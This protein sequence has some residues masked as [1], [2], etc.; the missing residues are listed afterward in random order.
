[1][2]RPRRIRGLRIAVSAVCGI[3]CLLLVVLWVRSYWR[4]DW[5][6]LKQP[7]K[8]LASLNGRLLF[9][10]VFNINSGQLRYTG[11]LPYHQYVGKSGTLFIARRDAMIPVGV[12]T[13]I[14][15]WPLVLALSTLTVGP[16][17][18]HRI[19]LRTLLI[20]TTLIAVGLGLIVWSMN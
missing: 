17:I 16:W 11:K 3:L 14:P 2:D 12:G 1:M 10:D 7:G 15:Y 13:S 20:A 8:S 18:P 6:R 9:N 5:V 4:L 19:S